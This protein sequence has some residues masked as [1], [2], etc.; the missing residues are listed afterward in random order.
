MSIY[1]D[2]EI[3]VGGDFVTFENVGDSVTGTVLYVGKHTFADGKVAI[4]LILDT[5][6][7]EK[8]LTAGQVQLSAKLREVRPDVGERVS[9]KFTNI[10]K[11]GGGKTLKHFDVKKKAGNGSIPAPTVTD[12]EEPF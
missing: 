7:G 5:D 9:I 6:D 3:R 1:D 10:E 2:P 12:D 11:R 4:K 8:T